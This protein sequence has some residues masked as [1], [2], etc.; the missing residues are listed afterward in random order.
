[1][2]ADRRERGG[3]RGKGV[4]GEEE[5]DE[6]EEID[7][8]FFFCRVMHHYRMNYDELLALPVEVFWELNKNVNRIQAEKDLRATQVAQAGQLTGEGVKTFEDSLRREMGRVVVEK[9][10]LDRAALSDLLASL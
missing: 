8:A 3:R 10:K 2:V 4:S 1:M 6:V 5:G 9:P 7:F